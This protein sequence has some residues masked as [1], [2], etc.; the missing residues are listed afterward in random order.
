MEERKENEG[1]SDNEGDKLNEPQEQQPQRQQPQRYNYPQRRPPKRKKSKKPTVAGS[2]LLVVAVLGILFSIVMVGSGFFLDNI[3]GLM[4]L[5][6]ETVNIEG[7]VVDENGDPIENAT[8]TI[9][10]T[11]LQTETNANGRYRIVGVPDGFQ[12]IRVEKS[13]YKTILLKTFVNND[14]STKENYNINDGE[15]H[16][17]G[18]EYDFTLPDGS[19]ELTYGMDPD[20]LEKLFG[21]LHGFLTV[22]GIITLVCSVMALIG[23]IFALKREHYGVAIAAAVVGI[24]SFGFAIGSILSIIAL[25]V[26][27]LASDEFESEDEEYY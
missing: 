25:F 19:G 3:D 12:E 11:H 24:F 26:I 13:G 16:R 15:V 22:I 10:D 8:I 2:L 5:S 27:L 6:N 20:T 21:D 18:N 17:Q 14:D 23:G 1:P 4:E 7:E 9:V